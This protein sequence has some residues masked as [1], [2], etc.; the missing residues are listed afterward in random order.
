MLLRYFDNL[1]YFNTHSYLG[2]ILSYIAYMKCGLM[3]LRYSFDRENKED[4]EEAF[5]HTITSILLLVLFNSSH[6]II[7]ND[8]N[9][10][11]KMVPNNSI[12]IP[13]ILLYKK[14]SQ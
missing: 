8:N 9:E 3:R 1:I 10:K 2:I 6:I 12:L 7:N 14:K 11:K 13:T 4:H 5:C